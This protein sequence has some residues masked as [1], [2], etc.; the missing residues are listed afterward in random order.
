[1]SS[2]VVVFPV[3]PGR[4]QLAEIDAIHTGGGVWGGDMILF[5]VFPVFPVFETPSP[6]ALGNA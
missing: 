5:P 2:K 6:L 3:I 1:M 4:I